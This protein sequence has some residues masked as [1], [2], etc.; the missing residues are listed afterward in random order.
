MISHEVFIHISQG[1]FA[2]TG[3]IVRLP[4]CQRSK[5]DGYGKISQCMTT[6][7]HSKAKTVCIFLGIY[8]TYAND[9]ANSYARRQVTKGSASH[10]TLNANHW[11][12]LLE[13]PSIIGVKS[14]ITTFTYVCRFFVNMFYCGRIIVDGFEPVDVKGWWRA[15]RGDNSCR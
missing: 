1:C 3:A 5:P 9:I 6:T 11:H 13:I 15:L 2:G 14:N 8:C 12:N 7:K 4:Q 10:N